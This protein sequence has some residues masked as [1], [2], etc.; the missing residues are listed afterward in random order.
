M[1]NDMVWIRCEAGLLLRHKVRHV[2]RIDW[3]RD[4]VGDKFIFFVF[5]FIEVPLNKANILE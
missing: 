2:L 1:G 5:V 3:F 4:V